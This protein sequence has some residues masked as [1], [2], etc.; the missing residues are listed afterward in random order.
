[1]TPITL[2]TFFENAEPADADT[3]VPKYLGRL[4]ANASTTEASVCNYAHPIRTLAICREL[5][6]T[7]GKFLDVAY[8]P[9]LDF[10]PAEQIA[11]AQACL[12]EL[13]GSSQTE[14]DNNMIFP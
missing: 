5:I 1:A 6:K 12:E 13:M 11:E 8:D 4:A 2:R 9:P 7:Y 3:P 10:P 14:I